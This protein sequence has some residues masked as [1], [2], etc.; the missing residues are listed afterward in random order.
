MRSRPDCVLCA[1]RQALTSG[2][3][4]SASEELQVAM[5]YRA[6]KALVS[7]SLELSPA[8]LASRAIRAAIDLLDIEDPFRDIKACYNRIALELVE[9]YRGMVEG[10]TDPLTVALKLAVAGNVVDFGV[11]KK[12]D[13]EQTVEQVLNLNFAVDYTHSFQEDLKQAETVLFVADNAGEIAF[14]KLLLEQMGSREIYVAVKSGPI[15][16]DATLQDAHQVGL[17]R[18]AQL[19]T[20]GSNSLGINLQECSEEFKRLLWS[21]DLVLGKGH[22]NFETMD[23][24]DRE[25]YLLLMAKCPVVAEEL[26]V[27]VGDTVLVKK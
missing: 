10:A 18:V 25:V 8:E 16:N 20:T 23:Q 2:R 9:R 1:A 3:M 6:M 11:G 13:L 7:C 5:L 15:L 22:A 17:N 4:A 21:V 24:L 19:I 27:K 14:D 12:F 26:G